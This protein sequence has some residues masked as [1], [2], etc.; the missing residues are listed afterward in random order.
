LLN[1][2]A[3]LLRKAHLKGGVGGSTPSLANYHFGII[4]RIN[5]GGVREIRT[6]SGRGN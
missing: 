5:D 1:Q 2:N 4:Q 3:V 6:E